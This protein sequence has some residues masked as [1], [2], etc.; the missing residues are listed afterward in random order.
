MNAIQ[1][2]FISVFTI[3][4][5]QQIKSLSTIMAKVLEIYTD[6]TQNQIKK[7]SL[8]QVASGQLQQ[9]TNS[10]PLLSNHIPSSVN[11]TLPQVTPFKSTTSS[12]KQARFAI[13]TREGQV[14]LF[15]LQQ[16]LLA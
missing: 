3:V 12:I 2:A 4:Y 10:N 5:Y 15:D 7:L 1:R 11:S 13:A 9:Q 14:L 8:L 16:Q 6:N